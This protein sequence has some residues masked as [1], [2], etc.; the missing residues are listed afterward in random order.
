MGR[1]WGLQRQVIAAP[2]N[3]KPGWQRD[4][5][6]MEMLREDY[7]IFQMKGQFNGTI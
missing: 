7:Q 5:G 2:F 4:S 3:W 6:H 1:F